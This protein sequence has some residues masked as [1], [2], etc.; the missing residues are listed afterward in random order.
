VQSDH[1]RVLPL[2]LLIGSI[3]LIWVDVLA[4]TLI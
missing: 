3:F 4:C 2:S 1:Q